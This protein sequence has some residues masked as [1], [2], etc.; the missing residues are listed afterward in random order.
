[1]EHGPFFR[2]AIEKYS[3]SHD[4]NGANSRYCPDEERNIACDEQFDEVLI[5][6]LCDEIQR[7]PKRKVHEA[8]KRKVDEMA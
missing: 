2:K 4:E 6:E 3:C 1:M 5:G 7:K 8:D